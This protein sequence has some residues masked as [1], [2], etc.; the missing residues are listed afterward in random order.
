MNYI[1]Y[2]T[3]NNIGYRIEKFVYKKDHEHIGQMIEQE[4]ATHDYTFIWE[5]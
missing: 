1:D 5:E 2:M 3:W 4:F